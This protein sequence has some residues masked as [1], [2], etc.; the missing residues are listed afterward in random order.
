MMVV[1]MMVMTSVDGYDG[2]HNQDGDQDDTDR[3]GMSFSAGVN[4]VVCL[5]CVHFVAC[6]LQVS[7]YP[8]FTRVSSPPVME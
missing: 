3:V 6:C 7:K 5:G 2:H 4:A 8:R 1:V